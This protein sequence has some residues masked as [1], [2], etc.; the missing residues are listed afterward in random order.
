MSPLNSYPIH[1]RKF[2]S[3]PVAARHANGALAG[4]HFMEASS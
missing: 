4:G 1:L 2:G 3:R